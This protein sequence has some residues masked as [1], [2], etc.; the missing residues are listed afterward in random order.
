MA[1]MKFTRRWVYFHKA[2]RYALPQ[3]GLFGSEGGTMIWIGTNEAVTVEVGGGTTLGPKRLRI[4]KPALVPSSRVC[5]TGQAPVG[6]E[7]IRIEAR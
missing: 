2:G 4:V 7:V 1:Q 3:A 5:T 6:P